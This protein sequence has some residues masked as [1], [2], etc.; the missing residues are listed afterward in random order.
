M[1]NGRRNNF[2]RPFFCL[3][4][5][6]VLPYNKTIELVWERNRKNAGTL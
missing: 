4:E 5:A 3:A 2:L 1:K 6:Y